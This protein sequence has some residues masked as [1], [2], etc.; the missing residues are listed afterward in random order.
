MGIG[1]GWDG[2]AGKDLS[3]IVDKAAIQLKVKSKNGILK[4]LPLAACLGDY[5]G[6][7]VWIG[8]HSKVL[9]K[10][11]FKMMNGLMLHFLYL[12]LVENAAHMDISNVKQFIVQFEASGDLYV[13]AI[14]IIPFTGGFKKRLEVPYDKFSLSVDEKLNESVWQKIQK[15]FCRL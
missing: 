13:N 3:S 4:S 1:F 12:N 5:G 14:K 11:E 6:N 2:W 8:F 15:R 7:Q 10:V 9:P